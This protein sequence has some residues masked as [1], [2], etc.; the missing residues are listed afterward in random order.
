MGSPFVA[1][2]GRKAPAWGS[3][4]IPPGYG[5]GCENPAARLIQTPRAGV[6]RGKAPLMVVLRGDAPA[7]L[8]PMPRCAAGCR[9]GKPLLGGMQRGD[10]VTPL[11]KPRG[12][13][14]M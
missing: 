3:R 10:E 4:R 7:A 2:G 6:P 11:A 5:P 8:L 12:Y 13:P 14:R 9:G 1:G